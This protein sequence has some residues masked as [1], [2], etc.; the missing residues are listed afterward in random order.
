M[1]NIKE[2]LNYLE[3]EKNYHERLMH[4]YS[5]L[6]II[7]NNIEFKKLYHDYHIIFYTYKFLISK[8]KRE[9]E[10]EK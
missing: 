2:L 1:K 9:Y 8:I 4:N 3:K 10:N 7:T 5:D 6:F